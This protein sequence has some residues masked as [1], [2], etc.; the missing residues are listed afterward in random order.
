MTKP[1]KPKKPS[2]FLF[3]KQYLSEPLG[4]GSITPSSKKLAQLMVANLD[5]EPDDVVV[6]LGPGTGVFTRALLEKGVLPKNLIL[7]EF[8]AD[9]A[10]YLR[11]EFPGVRIIEGD[12]CRLPQLLAELGQGAVMRILSGIPLRSLKPAQRKMITI[13]MSESLLPGGIAVQFT[14]FRTPPLPATVAGEHGMSGR[15]VAFTMGNVPPA[16]VWRYA[17]SE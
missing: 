6:E 12:A 9:F 3:L 15:Q 8:S 1:T 5:L 7:V 11:D 16:F 4:T 13:A 10:K 2:S 17:K 14:Y